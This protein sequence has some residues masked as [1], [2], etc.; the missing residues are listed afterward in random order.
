[1]KTS[2]RKRF[3][4]RVRELRIASGMSQEAFADHA[5]IARSY[6]SRIERGGANPSLDAIQALAEALGVDA[7]A[8]FEIVEPATSYDA[9]EVP[10]A[11]DGTCFNPG[12]ASPRDGSFR[13]GEKSA[14]LRLGS[15]EEALAHLRK[16]PVAKWRRP[17][18][19]G[20]W[21]LVSAVHW[22]KLKS[23]KGRSR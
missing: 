12:L 3:G 1:M 15:F 2:L 17:N 22:R 10:Y 13:V 21:G 4:L 16:M 5:S 23:A 14:E 18:V 20:N 8:L 11:E 7:G 19:S 6:M 9:V